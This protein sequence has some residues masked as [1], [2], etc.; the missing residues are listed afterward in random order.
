MSS[1]T[2]LPGLSKNNFNVIAIY[3]K[4]PVS[5]RAAYTWRS[6]FYTSVYAGNSA[7]LAT[8]PIFTKQFGWLDASLNYEL[9]HDWTVYAQGS[10]LL[11]TRLVTF[12]GSQ[13]IPDSYTI[14]DRQALLGVR[15]KFN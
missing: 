14:N 12:Y 5:F 2:T 10:N 11:R 7:Q 1:T 13:T 15:F 8:N 6:Q 3:E 4:G 9:T